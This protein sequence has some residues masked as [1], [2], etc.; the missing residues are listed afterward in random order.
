MTGRFESA[1]QELH[2]GAGILHS[3]IKLSH[4]LRPIIVVIHTDLTGHPFLKRSIEI[5][6]NGKSPA[7]I[8]SVYP[9]SGFLFAA[10]RLK[11]NA[12]NAGEIFSVLKPAMFDALREDD[13]CWQALPDGSYSYGASKWGTPFAVIK[14]SVTGESFLLHFG[15]SGNYE[16]QFFN[17]HDPSRDDAWLY[18]RVGL[19]GP[20]PFRILEPDESVS[21]P[22]VYL[23]HFLSPIWIRRFKVCTPTSGLPCF[24]RFPLIASARWRSIPGDSWPMKSRRGASN[25]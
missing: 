11:E 6:N 7:A 23:G 12:P 10:H 19:A 21:T 3:S 20:G 16:F 2:G 14:N 25:R 18:F 17:N 8:G 1:D 13:F 9:M 15:W 4:A 24:L 5:R 22:P